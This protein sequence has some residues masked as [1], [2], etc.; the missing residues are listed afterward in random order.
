MVHVLLGPTAEL[1]RGIHG[2]LLDHPPN[3]VTYLQPA[4]RHRF[5]FSTKAAADPF[6]TPSLMEVI[7]YALPDALKDAI[8]GVHSSRLPAWGGVPWIADTDDLILTLAYGRPLVR[9][10]RSLPDLHSEASLKRA[11]TMTAAYAAPQCVEVQLRTERARADAI[12]YLI[13]LPHLNPAARDALIAKLEVV[14]PAY[15]AGPR[16]DARP[17]VSVTYMGR[18]YADKG[19]PVAA[20]VFRRLGTTRA[21]GIEMTWVGPCPE[22]LRNAL[23]GVA[24]R[25]FGPRDEFM[26]LLAATDMFLSPTPYESYGSALAEAAAN[27][28]VLLSTKGPGMVHLDEI[29]E[30]GK[31]GS[32]VNAQSEDHQAAE[33]LSA[34]EALLTH[35]Q[36]MRQMQNDNRNLAVSGPLSLSRRD[37]ALTDSYE[38]LRRVA[39]DLPVAAVDA[40]TW[41]SLSDEEMQRRYARYR[42]KSRRRVVRE[43]SPRH[44]ST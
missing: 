42:G 35:P 22:P 4:H 9:G 24:F 41:R 17:K 6:Q 15:P 40:P 18:S 14:R 11:A 39:H 36:R 29:F 23:P 13:D 1:H 2:G 31:H 3:G 44:R 10:V 8:A 20:A 37:R 16:R 33:F 21:P 19:G 26:D 12:A 38:R 28:C 43:S 27:G 34:I 7:D 30:D 32:F 5:A 25:Q